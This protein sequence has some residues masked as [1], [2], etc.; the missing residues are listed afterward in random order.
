MSRGP[1]HPG[2]A[3]LRCRRPGRGPPGL[4]EG[5]VPS[6]CRRS[7]APGPVRALGRAAPPAW[8]WG[9]V[10]GGAGGARTGGT[11]EGREGGAQGLGE[12]PRRTTARAA[13]GA[14]GAAPAWRGAAGPSAVRAFILAL[15]SHGLIVTSPRA[16]GQSPGGSHP[17]VR[18]AAPGPLPTPR[19]PARR[20]APS[21]PGRTVLSQAERRGG[22]PR[23]GRARAGSARAVA[24]GAAFPGVP[25][26][27]TG[28]RMLPLPRLLL[29]PRLCGSD[30]GF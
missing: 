6:D 23:A 20:P 25:W 7:T 16:P 3:G 26:G 19:S 27:P 5:L 22:G 30:G 13:R 10:P 24:W 2:G 15:A 12:G 21:P 29:Q 8:P 4:A 18:T 17:G 28:T 1:A 9:T 11:A 14:G